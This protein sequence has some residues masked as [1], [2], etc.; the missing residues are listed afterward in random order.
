MN[1]IRT[2]VVATVFG[3]IIF[4][5]PAIVAYIIARYLVIFGVAGIVRSM[6]K[7]LGA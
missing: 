4:I 2:Y 3:I 7:E 1:A 5:V 6:R